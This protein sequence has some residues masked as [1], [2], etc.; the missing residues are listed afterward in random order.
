MHM[1][2]IPDQRPEQRAY[3]DQT[4]VA[5]ARPNE[6]ANMRGS[7]SVII[8]VRQNI[9]EEEASSSKPSLIRGSSPCQM[10]KDEEPS[11]ELRR[12]LQR[13]PRVA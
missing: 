2:Q 3:P 13:D 9:S 10:K 11:E 4:K 5:N 7:P 6:R 8:K 1:Y 12:W